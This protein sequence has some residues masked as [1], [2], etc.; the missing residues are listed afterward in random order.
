MGVLFRK[1]RQ[2][3][4]EEID[5]VPPPTDEE[6]IR[7]LMASAAGVLVLVGVKLSIG[8][9]DLLP[10]AVAGDQLGTELRKAVPVACGLA[11]A[12][13]VHLVLKSRESKRN[14]KEK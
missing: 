11:T 4:Q 13:L 10:P 7:I 8:R 12:Y 14:A 5:A 1:G 2:P 9:F 3:T 6:L